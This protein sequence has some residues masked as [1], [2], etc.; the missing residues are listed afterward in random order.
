M[1]TKNGF[2]ELS[3]LEKFLIYFLLPLV[4]FAGILIWLIEDNLTKQGYLLKLKQGIFFFLSSLAA[5]MIIRFLMDYK[6]DVY[7]LFVWVLG[8]AAAYAVDRKRSLAR[9]KRAMESMG[10]NLN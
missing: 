8:F 10:I 2:K 1:I 6:D 4:F 5:L 7:L 9:K 3:F